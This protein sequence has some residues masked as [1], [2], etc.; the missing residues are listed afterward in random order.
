M[1][2]KAAEMDE[3]RLPEEGVRSPGPFQFNLE[4]MVVAWNRVGLDGVA[5]AGIVRIAPAGEFDVDLSQVIGIE[6]RRGDD[7]G[8]LEVHPAF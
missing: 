1:P 3:I 8:V 2:V 5:A 7:V 4:R 6:E